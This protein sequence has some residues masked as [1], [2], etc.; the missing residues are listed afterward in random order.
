MPA[1]GMSILKIDYIVTP[2]YIL[3][4]LGFFLSGW[5]ITVQDAGAVSKIHHRHRHHSRATVKENSDVLVLQSFAALVVDRQTGESLINKNADTILPI[6]S[7]SKLMTAIVVLD[8]GLD[9]EE[10]LIIA[11]EDVDTLRHSGSR[12]PVGTSLTRRDT[13]LLALMASENRAAHALGRTYPGGMEAFVAAMNN[14][15]VSLGLTGTRF[16]EPT[17]LSEGNVSSAYDLVKML[18]AASNYALIRDFSTRELATVQCGR[19]L[20]SFHN[21]D[22]LV[23]NPRWQIGLSKTGYTGDAGRCLVMQARVAE[24]PLAIVLLNSQGKLTRFA[25]ANRIRKW[26]E[27]MQFQSKNSYGLLRRNVMM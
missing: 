17:G 26:L 10:P 25:D 6:A 3:L 11:K 12:L 7:I 14:K 27:K 18:D 23:L 15:A 5:L 24:R 22:R 9:L 4:A 20:V 16:I 2:K 19:R 8:A 13:L 21:T 1:G